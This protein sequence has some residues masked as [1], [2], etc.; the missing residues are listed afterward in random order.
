[1]VIL[2]ALLA[3]IVIGWILIGPRIL[4]PAAPAAGETGLEGRWTLTPDAPLAT[5][6]DVSAAGYRLAGDLA[7]TGSGRATRAGEELV[8]S[9]DAACPDGAGRYRVT[10]ADV[11]RFGLLPG[12]RAQSLTL[13]VV[14][15]P[16]GA[17]ARVL[18]GTWTLRAS[19]RDGVH[20]ICDPPNE[21][22]AITGHW[23]EPSGCAGDG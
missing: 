12:N 18:A 19:G 2:V 10:L 9:D 14:D 17:R 21:E 6:F 4:P 16:C 15:D 13:T 20:G 1:M 5:T 8:V 22:A 11:D 23:P 3:A 7:F